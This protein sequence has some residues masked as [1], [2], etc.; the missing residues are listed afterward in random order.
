MRIVDKPFDEVKP[1]EIS[2]DDLNAETVTRITTAVS[3]HQSGGPVVD[4]TFP[5]GSGES[6]TAADRG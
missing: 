5:E 1:G 2:V 4:A 3:N 6:E